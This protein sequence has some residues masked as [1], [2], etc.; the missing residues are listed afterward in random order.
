MALAAC[1]RAREETGCNTAALTGGCFQN[2]LLL[3][4]TESKLEAAG[5]RVLTHRL[6]PPNDGG[7]C[8][9][10]AVYAMERLRAGG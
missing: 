5:F 9:G 10:Q 8:L 6:I 7:I 1:L 4:L 3:E 2:T